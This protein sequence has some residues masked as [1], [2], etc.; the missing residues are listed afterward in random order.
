MHWDVRAQR[1]VMSGSASKEKLF[2]AVRPS[3]PASILTGRRTAAQKEA[4]PA[5]HL[6]LDGR[7]GSVPPPR[8]RQGAMWGG[9]PRK[10]PLLP[11]LSEEEVAAQAATHGGISHTR[12][13]HPAGRAPLRCQAQ[14]WIPSGNTSFNRRSDT[15][16]VRCRASSFFVSLHALIATMAHAAPA[17]SQRSER[18]SRRP[19][20][21][22]LRD[23][24]SR[25]G[26]PSGTC[27]SSRAPKYRLPPPVLQGSYATRRV[28]C[29][30]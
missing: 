21:A 16:I 7:F 22:R 3:S 12:P 15:D 24:P 13:S 19:S 27:L 5:Y 20:D 1:V 25:S 14:V 6:L 11:R 9:P 2:R 28:F 10:I 29:E 18:T 23:E 8:R 26:E 4:A 17:A 30:R